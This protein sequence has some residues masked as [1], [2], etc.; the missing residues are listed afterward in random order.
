MGYDHYYFYSTSGWRRVL[1]IPFRPWVA[2][3]ANSSAPGSVGASAYDT[4]YFYLCVATNTWKRIAL[5]T[6]AGSAPFPATA[7]VQANYTYTDGS[8][9]YIAVAT[10][11]WL[12][13]ALS[14][15]SGVASGIPVPTASYYPGLPGF[16]TFDSGYWYYCWGQ[17]QWGR[18]ALVSF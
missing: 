16:E 7:V 1:S 17:N 6:W 2:A 15:F 14:S 13:F 3:P 5:A 18:A 11:T 4:N 8:Y 10:N 9:Y 12:R